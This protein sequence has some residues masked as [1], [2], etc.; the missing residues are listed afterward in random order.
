MPPAGASEAADGDKVER[1]VA[2]I[3]PGGRHLVVRREGACFRARVVDGPAISRHR[4]SVDVLF[5]SVAV[6]AG[7]SA[8]GVLMTGMGRDGAEGMAE[9]KQRGAR[10]VA[11]DQ[12]SSVVFGMPKEAIAL[13]VV[14][15]V[16]SLSRIAAAI[17]EGASSLRA[18]GSVDG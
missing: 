10:T 5:K 2:L 7:P 1:G 12:A 13:G 17:L 11:Q 15:E 16:V 8:V 9:M 6:A 4:P 18:G 3:A 14:D